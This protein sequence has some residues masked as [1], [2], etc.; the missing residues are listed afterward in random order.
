MNNLQIIKDEKFKG[1]YLSINFL[2]PIIK[3][4]ISN[5][6][7]WASTITK[8]SAKYITEREIDLIFSDLYD[9]SYGARVEILGDLYNIE[10]RMECLNSTFLPSKENVFKK[11]LEVFLEIIY[12]PYVENNALDPKIVARQKALIEDKLKERKENKK[13]YAV[14]KL[15]EIL[16]QG[17]PS[18]SYLYGDKENLD[19]VTP[20][21]AYKQYL[22][23]LKD[24]NVEVVLAGNVEDY[25]IDLIKDNVKFN[26]Y[27]YDNVMQN[28]IKEK[29]SETIEK[30]DSSQSV[31][32][33]G[34][35]I[36][37]YNVEDSY[38]YFVYNSILGQNPSSKLFQ[39]VREK[40]SLSY[41]INSI[42][43]RFKGELVIY[44]GINSENYES[45]KKI[46]FKQINEMKNGNIT[47]NEFATAKKYLIA[48]FY[49]YCNS[50]ESIARYYFYNKLCYG[51]TVSIQNM[52]ENIQNISL[53]E[54]IDVAK[55]V[56]IQQMYLLKG[57]N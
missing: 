2:L 16:D 48:E 18:S 24:A 30:A 17:E 3:S 47:E 5:N 52:I 44:T 10:F 39:E 26:S 41:Y 7:I 40:A 27:K 46:I 25:M 35:K 43:R 45:A 51:K 49:D 6:V 42:F 54:V 32:V 11:A 20:E 12:N 15:E 1:I 50:T 8:K 53:Q 22:K 19:K 33:L 55:N 4:E 37:K 13:V 31:L 29:L 23:V 36:K 21:S 14:S 57:G 34:G 56:E 9:S 28:N 38:K